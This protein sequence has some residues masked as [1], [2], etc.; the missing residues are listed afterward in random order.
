[1]KVGVYMPPFFGSYG[2]PSMGFGYS[3]YMYGGYG[4]GFHHH[5]YFGGFG[6]HRPWHHFGYSW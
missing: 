6:Y 5:P 4:Y 3:P 1:M 2:Y